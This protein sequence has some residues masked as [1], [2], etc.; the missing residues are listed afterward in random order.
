MAQKVERLRMR[1]SEDRWGG[2]PTRSAPPPDLFF[3]SSLQETVTLSVEL[4]VLEARQDGG[5]P[6]LPPEAQE[7]PARNRS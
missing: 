3:R 4:Q 6:P 5:L 2:E 1:F 7:E